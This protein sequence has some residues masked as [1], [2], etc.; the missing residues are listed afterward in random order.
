MYMYLERRVFYVKV[1]KNTLKKIMGNGIGVDASGTLIRLAWVCCNEKEEFECDAENKIFSNNSSCY[2]PGD[3]TVYS[4]SCLIKPKIVSTTYEKP[5]VCTCNYKPSIPFSE[6]CPYQNKEHHTA[7]EQE[8]LIHQFLKSCPLWSIPKSFCYL[9]PNSSLGKV[10]CCVICWGDLQT[11][12]HSA[13]PFVSKHCRELNLTGSRAKDFENMLFSILPQGSFCIHYQREINCVLKAIEFLAC[14]VP[15]SLFR[16]AKTYKPLNSILS[17]LNQYGAVPLK[18]A[19]FDNFYPYLLVNLK[20]GVSF[21]LVTG[22]NNSIRVGGSTIGGATLMGLLRLL[23][24]NIHSPLDA[25]LM[26]QS[27]DNS[28]IDLLISDIYG[29]DYTAAGLKGTTIASTCGKLQNLNKF[30]KK[31]L[32]FKNGTIR[33]TQAPHNHVPSLNQSVPSSLQCKPINT[34]CTDLS[35]CS[36]PLCCCCGIRRWER[37]ATLETA[38]AAAGILLNQMTVD[39]CSPTSSHSPTATPLSSCP[40]VNEKD[41]KQ[42]DSSSI[43]STVKHQ[44]LDY[45]IFEADIARS[46]CT[47][48]TY[49]VAQLAYFNSVV[50]G[51]SRI[52]LVGYYLDMPG[53]LSSVQHCV[54][55]WSS[56]ACQI[57][58]SRLAPS[59]GA[60]GASL[61]QQTNKPG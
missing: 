43:I 28:S 29:G 58:F 38:A 12:L 5:F 20:A 8:Q 44:R 52:L 59:L 23:C 2:E 61:C 6:K 36:D 47:M 32:P 4:S 10:I 39:M 37:N 25:F 3:L 53:Y 54:D 33:W 18:K 30:N 41:K 40:T 7:W 56:G 27:G 51:C 46:I 22:H 19:D 57:N 1:R 21:H 34:D 17:E 48:T 9:T 35:Y 11:A 16:Y 13:K 45:D 49:N 24:K 55:F 15:G 50:Y 60:I 26:A 31:I 14:H 42:D